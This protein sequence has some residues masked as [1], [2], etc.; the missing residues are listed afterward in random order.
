MRRTPLLGL[1]LLAATVSL[2]PRGAGGSS[3]DRAAVIR[4]LEEMLVTGLPG[5]TDHDEGELLQA[6]V[7]DLIARG[8]SRIERLAVRAA[9]PLRVSISHPVASVRDPASPPALVVTAVDVLK[10]PRP[11][12]YTARI[13]VSLDGGDLVEAWTQASGKSGGFS[14]PDRLGE[15]VMRPGGHHLRVRAY[16]TFGAGKSAWTEVRDL[17]ELF[18]AVYDLSLN[19]VPDGRA[20][21]LGPAAFTAADFDPA[22]PPEGLE[23][24]LTQMIAPYA[25]P[26]PEPPMWM[27][28]YCAHRAADPKRPVDTRAIC[29]VLYF[30]TRTASGGQL[31]FRT[32]EVQLLEDRVAWV[33]LEV[34]R[35]EG[36]IYGERNADRL[37]ALGELLQSAPGDTAAADTFI[38][39]ADI[40]ITPAGVRRGGRAEVAVTLRNRG[41][42]WVYKAFVTITYGSS[43]LAHAGRRN[44]SVDIPPLGER[45]VR[46]DIRW[47]ETYGWVMAEAYQ[48]S[49]HSPH[50]GVRFDPTPTDA[51]VIR[52]LNA[53]AAPPEVLAEFT[54]AR[55][56]NGCQVVIR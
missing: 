26:K 29:A 56:A 51:C 40:V 10:L 3:F 37:S 12:P 33:P 43:P 22:L 30:E 46:M 45:V 41:Q 50:E 14:L 21:L 31:W 8:D 4:M 54:D 15:A 48:L 55:D 23:I 16:L 13:F 2:E 18:Y 53:Q 36:I 7:T 52:L 27:S 5:E 34:P 25:R 24:W 42:D 38:D 35:L 49:E 32:A 44:F 47:P 9:A 39:P 1:M 6:A 28:H 11:V 19:E 20:L 17:P